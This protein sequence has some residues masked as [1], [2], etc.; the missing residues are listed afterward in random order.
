MLLIEIDKKKLDYLGVFVLN[1][2]HLL[3][4]YYLKIDVLM[5][6]KQM[7]YLSINGVF[8]CVTVGYK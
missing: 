4:L 7:N 2:P 3:K 1:P 8:K 5:K 6:P